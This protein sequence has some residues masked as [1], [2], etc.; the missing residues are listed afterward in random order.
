MVE[1][2]DD[3]DKVVVA[4]GDA[5]TDK[6]VIADKGDNADNDINANN[7]SDDDN[8][9]DDDGLAGPTSRGRKS[10]ATIDNLLHPDSARERRASGT[11][12]LHTESDDGSKPVK[13]M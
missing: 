9:N 7:G 10:K 4:D 11:S 1:V 6:D 12:Q 3:S 2:N 13:T 8:N 5:N